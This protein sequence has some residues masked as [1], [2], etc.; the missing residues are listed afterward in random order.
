MSNVVFDGIGNQ[1][2]KGGRVEVRGFG[3]FSLNHRPPRIGRNPKTG[4]RVEV[5]AKRAVH[6]KMGKEMREDVNGTE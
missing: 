2:A 6:F 3:I 1:L 5:P 4:E